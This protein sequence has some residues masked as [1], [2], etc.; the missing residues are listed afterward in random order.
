MRPEAS[1]DFNALHPS[2]IPCTSFEA[3][4]TE[5]PMEVDAVEASVDAPAATATPEVVR[6][7]K[8]VQEPLAGFSLFKVSCENPAATTM[9]G[10][11][12]FGAAISLLL[13][14]L[15]IQLGKCGDS[16]LTNHR[17][18]VR[19]YRCLQSTASTS[20]SK[21][22]PESRKSRALVH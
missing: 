22:E 19:P 15:D 6:P 10:L 2:P 7:T 1:Q 13:G 18:L 14:F 16:N 11:C 5:E 9:P 8:D 12:K 20:I 3:P 21:S 4:D 17:C